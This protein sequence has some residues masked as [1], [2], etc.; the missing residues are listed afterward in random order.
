MRQESLFS[1]FRKCLVG[2][3]TEITEKGRALEESQIV[4]EMFFS[5]SSECV[6]LMPR[7]GIL[8]SPLSEALY[9][10]CCDFS[11]HMQYR[12]PHICLY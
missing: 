8:L 11:N 3:Y 6:E 12:Q 7:N 5:F 10:D 1:G 4:P 2:G 9:I